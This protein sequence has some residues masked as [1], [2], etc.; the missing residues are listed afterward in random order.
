MLVE[1]VVLA[2]LIAL[3]LGGA[4]VNGLIGMGLAL[5][6]VNGL[7]NALDPKAA[8]VVL[9]LISPFLS[10]YQLVHNRAFVKGWGRLRSLALWAVIGSMFG[11][12]LLVLLPT[13]AIGLA[14]GLFTVHFVIDRLRKERPALARHTERRLAPIAGLVGGTTNSALGASGPIIGSYLFAIGLRGREFAFAIS[15]VFFIS[16]L[17]RV[18]SLAV[19]GQYTVPLATLSVVLLVPSLV[20]QYIGQQLQGRAHPVVFQ[21]IL[22]VVLFVS[23]VIVLSQGLR[24]LAAW[25]GLAV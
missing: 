25:L 23:S 4:I 7:A 20:G 11:A 15:V 19:L 21:R 12:Q 18:G 16:A 1:P 22:L 14:L 2:V 8:V 5:V 10:S 3:F 13:W 17:I 24:G 6:A 9:S